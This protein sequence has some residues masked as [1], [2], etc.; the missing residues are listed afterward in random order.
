MC[1]QGCHHNVVFDTKTPHTKG[2]LFTE[3]N[4]IE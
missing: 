2:G 3:S 1:S 4:I